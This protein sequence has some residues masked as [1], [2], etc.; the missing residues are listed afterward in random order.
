MPIINQG[1]TCFVFPNPTSNLLN[2]RISTNKKLPIFIS[3]RN[4]L[5]QVLLNEKIAA[6]QYITH[7]ISM[8]KW[9]AGT[10]ALIITNGEETISKKIIN[11]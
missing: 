4:A 11:Y 6:E 2:L 8:K 1:L 9:A 5:G 10:Y 3:L 7:S